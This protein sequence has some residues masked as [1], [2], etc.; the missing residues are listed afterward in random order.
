MEAIG[1][2]LI[3][4]LITVLG[5]DNALLRRRLRQLEADNRRMTARARDQLANDLHRI[6]LND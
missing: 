5:L 1:F 3:A 4:F 2:G 6:G